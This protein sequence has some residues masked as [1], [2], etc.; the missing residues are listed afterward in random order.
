MGTEWVDAYLARIGAGRP[1]RPDV[2]TL[3]ELQFAHLHSVPFENLSVHAGEPITLDVP[4]L[5]DKVVT[6]RR[7]GFCYELNGAFGALLTALGYDVSLLA[8]RVFS[9]GRPG[10]PFA[11][12]ALRV[13][14]D[15]PWLV[16][17]GFGRFATTPLRMD[18][19]GDQAEWAGVF[20]LRLIGDDL[21]VLL[22]GEPAY[23]LDTRPYELRDFVPTCWWTSTSPD[24]HFTRSLTCSML[25][26]AGR[27]TLSGTTLI[28]TVDGRRHEDVIA[29]EQLAAAY[30]DY[31]GMP[32]DD[33]PT[34]IAAAFLR[35]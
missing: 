8:A 15:E 10:M 5:I 6:R 34:R 1:A 23:R 4:S 26:E 35:S 33:P 29:A 19:P 9:D 32:L 21:D 2:E 28:R 24:S 20:R 7:G 22:D 13:D 14:L 31:F 27:I 30:R 3:R 12:M 25:T 18:E 17:V 16:D 11:H